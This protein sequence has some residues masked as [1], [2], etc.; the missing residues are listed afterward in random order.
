M[1]YK[2]IQVVA[3]IYGRG[4]LFRS[5]V[6]YCITITMYE[7]MILLTSILFI[8]EGEKIKFLYLKMPNPNSRECD[9]IF[10]TIAERI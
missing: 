8:Q 3:E 2:N 5:E 9:F 7:V 1:V 10:S 4:H 6:H